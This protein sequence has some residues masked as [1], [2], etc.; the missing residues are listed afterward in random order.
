MT[1]DGTLR[2]E[3]D[4]ACRRSLPLPGAAVCTILFVMIFGHWA[5]ASIAS[6]T[7]WKEESYAFLLVASFLPDFLDKTAN[8]VFC[9]PGRGFGHSLVVF[10]A[11]MLLGWAVLPRVA[12]SRSSLIPAA[13]LWTT[14]LVGDM[15]V[16]NVLFWPFLGPLEPVE[17]FGF[18]WSFYRMYV[19][20]NNPP[21]LAM[22]LLCIALAV[23]LWLVQSSRPRIPVPVPVRSLEKPSQRQG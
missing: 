23:W 8:V 4:S 1:S 10:A 21:M 22:D 14:H 5:C 2:I 9:M 12:M 20:F 3:S 16:L 13:I 17:R 6:R 11:F 18:L 15:V 7:Y 19:Q